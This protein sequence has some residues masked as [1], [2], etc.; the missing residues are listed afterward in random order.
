MN[1]LIS[2]LEIDAKQFFSKGKLSKER[3]AYLKY[4][5]CISR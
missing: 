4:T 1:E 5:N 3:V 2:F